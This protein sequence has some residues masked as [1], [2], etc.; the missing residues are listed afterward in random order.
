MQITQQ[1]KMKAPRNLIKGFIF[2]ILIPGTQLKTPINLIAI[3]KQFDN[4]NK[5]K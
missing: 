1:Y 2:P 5:T 4:F 3:L